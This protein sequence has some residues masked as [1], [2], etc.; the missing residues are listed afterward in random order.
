MAVSTTGAIESRL[1]S[2]ADQ[3]RANSGLK[4]SEHPPQALV[5]RFPHFAKLLAEQ[6][7]KLSMRFYLARQAH[8]LLLSKLIL[9]QVKIPELVA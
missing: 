4:S 5:D 3:L 2:V 9:G 6:T 8:D 1:W 7:A